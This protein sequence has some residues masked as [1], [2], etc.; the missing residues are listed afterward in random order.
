MQFFFFVFHHGGYP[1]PLDINNAN[2]GDT[3]QDKNDGKIF[4]QEHKNF[5][6]M[7]G[8]ACPGLRA[9]LLNNYA[10]D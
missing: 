9:N 3:D 1:V 2:Q 6:A 7:L 4:F 10:S 8:S 5:N